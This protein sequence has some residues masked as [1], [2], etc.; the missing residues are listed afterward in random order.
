[1]STGGEGGMLTTNDEVLWRKVWAF[2]DHG[3][4]YRWLHESFSTN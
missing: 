3:N 2:K 4:T 1:M